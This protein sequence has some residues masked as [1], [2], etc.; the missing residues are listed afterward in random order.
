MYRT[1]FPLSPHPKLG[2]PVGDE[3]VPKTIRRERARASESERECACK[4]DKMLKL[5]NVGKDYVEIPYTMLTTLLCDEKS[6]KNG[7]QK[8]KYSTLD[9]SI[10]KVTIS[11]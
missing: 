6:Y 1:K 2:I 5:G 8:R 10:N 7:V 9:I 4:Y 3:L 11:S